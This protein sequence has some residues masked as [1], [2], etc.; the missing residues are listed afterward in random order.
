MSWPYMLI[1][2]FSKY[3]SEDLLMQF[4]MFIFTYCINC[5]CLAFK[6]PSVFPFTTSKSTQNRCDVR[7]LLIKSTVIWKKTLILTLSNVFE[8]YN[9][10][11]YPV[12]LWC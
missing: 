2:K 6:I 8:K 1:A 12:I 11:L 7:T 3:N 10:S 4:L 9:S 5:H